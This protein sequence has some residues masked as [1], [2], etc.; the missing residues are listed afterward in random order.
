MEIRHRGNPLAVIPGGDNLNI[1]LI[2]FMGSGKTSAG[3]ILAARTGRE[4][5]DIDAMIEDEQKMK[6]P[7]IFSGFGEKRFREIEAEIIK[8]ISSRDGLIISTGGGVVLNSDNV[9]NLKKNGVLVW[10]QVSCEDAVRRTLPDSG[11]PL[12][13]VSKPENAVRELLGARDPLYA[14]SDFKVD[15]TDKTVEEVAEE[16]MNIMEGQE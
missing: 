12:L 7:E 5:V 9:A 15:T 2:G 14:Q 1:V 10:L 3:K 11:R 16:I 6:V 13:N 8:R 4:F